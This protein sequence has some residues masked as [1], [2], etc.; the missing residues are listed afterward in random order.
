MRF[1]EAKYWDLEATFETAEGQ[2]FP[3]RLHSLDGERLIAGKDFDPDTG[4]PKE[5]KESLVW[6]GDED[7]AALAQ[8]LQG[9]PFTILSAKEKDFTRSPA[10]PFT[11]STLQQEG[12]RK[13]R[14]DAKR[15]MRAAQRLYENGF[16]HL[17]ANRLGGA[18]PPR[19]SASRARTSRRSTAATTSRPSRAPIRTRSRTRRRHTRRFVRRAIRSVRSPRSPKRSA[20]MSRRST[21]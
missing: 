17:H 20:G 14:F 18:F 11:T 13:L 1:Q 19:R 10:P 4:K 3:A 16:H 2:T 6:L 15:T 7:T 21:N 5:G 9:A 8:G 12:N